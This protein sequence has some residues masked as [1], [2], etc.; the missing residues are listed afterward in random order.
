[1]LAEAGDGAEAW[2]LIQR[3]RPQIALMALDMPEIY[4]FGVAR[5]A[6][7]A[8]LPTSVVILTM[9]KDELYFKKGLRE[10]VNP[11]GFPCVHCAR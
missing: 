11:L 1:M 4:G 8:G 9:H 3:H 5:Q 10:S 6:Q 2:E 7:A